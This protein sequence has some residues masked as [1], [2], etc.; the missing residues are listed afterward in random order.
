MEAYDELKKAYEEKTTAEFG[1]LVDSF[2]SMSCDD[3][4][5]TIEEHMTQYEWTWNTFTAI[6]SRADLKNDDEFGKGLQEFAKSD[7]KDWILAQISI[8]LLF[9]HC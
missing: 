4:K 5:T 7:S 1:A 8:S 3:R 2:A 6:I 9:Q